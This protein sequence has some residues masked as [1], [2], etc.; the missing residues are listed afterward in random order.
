MS[1]ADT[2]T[3]AKNAKDTK[4]RKQAEQP[5]HWTKIEGDFT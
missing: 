5:V 2:K 3:N 1:D 4:M